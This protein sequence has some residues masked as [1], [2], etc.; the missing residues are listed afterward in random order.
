MRSV[1]IGTVAVALLAW[2]APSGAVAN[3]PPYRPPNMQT[4]WGP[5]AQDLAG[6]Y[7]MN[8][9]PNLPCQVVPSRR[10]PDR[11]MFVNENGDQTDGYIRGNRVFVPKWNLGGTVDGDAIRWD[12]QSVW[13]R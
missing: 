11:A 2:A 10:A 4:P 12:N 6:T 13:A 5:S 9:N 1:F 7:Y 3:Y 8:G